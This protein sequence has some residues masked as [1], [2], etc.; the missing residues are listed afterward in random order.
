VSRQPNGSGRYYVTLDGADADAL[1]AA[2]RAQDRPPT[3]EAGL[4][5]AQTL[6]AEATGNGDALGEA[7]A[8]RDEARR[9]LEAARAE[10]F[11]L[12]RRVIA[13]AG[14]G[15][16]GPPRWEWPLEDLLADREWWSAWLPRL[17]EVLGRPLAQYSVNGHQPHDERGYV[18]LMSYLFPPVRLG[19]QVAAEWHSLDYPAMVRRQSAAGGA[20]HRP[21]RAAPSAGI[22][23]I[24]QPAIRRVAVALAALQQTA[25]PGADPVLRIR[26]EDEL[27]GPW[28]RTLRRLTGDEMADLPGTGGSM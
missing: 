18:D 13:S 10:N 16:A 19:D 22:A 25:V 28:L 5:I 7:V 11:A 4:R 8:E 24:W 21:G 3:T 20:A 23:D 12:R 1:E 26:T 6:R 14:D 17:Y 2:A 15:N 9:R 27:T